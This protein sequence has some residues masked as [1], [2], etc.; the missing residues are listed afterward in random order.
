MD[1]IVAWLSAILKIAIIMVGSMVYNRK[2]S[3]W[4]LKVKPLEN[5]Q[6]IKITYHIDTV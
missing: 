4:S 2:L 3:K 6:S 1:F 5:C